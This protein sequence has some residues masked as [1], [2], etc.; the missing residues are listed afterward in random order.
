MEDEEQRE[1]DAEVTTTKEAF[2]STE[3]VDDGS[4]TTTEHIYDGYELLLDIDES[5]LDDHLPPP[6]G[7]CCSGPCNV[8][9]M[10]R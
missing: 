5:V 4:G 1:P 8:A 7:E 2:V 9:L 6:A 10:C 3:Q